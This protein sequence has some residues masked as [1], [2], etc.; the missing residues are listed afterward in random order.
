MND[1]D[2]RS[3][4][5]T[6]NRN[7]LQMKDLGAASELTRGSALITPWIEMGIPP[8]NYWCPGC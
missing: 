5:Q 6:E 4:R 3:V 2:E 7:A 1:T 8:Y